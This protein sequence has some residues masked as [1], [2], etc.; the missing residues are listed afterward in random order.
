MV[1]SRSFV[2]ANSV[3]SARGD[4]RPQFVGA[5][6]GD[7]LAELDR[8]VAFGAEIVAPRQRAQRVAVQDVLDGEADRAVHLMGD[9][10][11]FFGRFRAADFGGDRFEEDAS[12]PN[13]ALLAIVS[14]ADVAA[15]SAAADSPAS[16]ARLCCTAWNFEIFFSNATRSLA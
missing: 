16:L 1:L 15:A 8:P 4:Q 5:A 11:A 10:A 6:R 2:Q 14:A 3:R 13:E 7:A 9:G 12:S